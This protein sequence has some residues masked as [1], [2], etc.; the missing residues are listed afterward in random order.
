MDTIWLNYDP[1]VQYWSV[2][3][4]WPNSGNLLLESSA[5]F[6]IQFPFLKMLWFCA[7]LHL[8]WMKKIHFAYV[9]EEYLYIPTNTGHPH[10]DCLHRSAFNEKSMK[11]SIPWGQYK[12]LKND[13]FDPQQYCHG[14]SGL[15]CQLLRTHSAQSSW[16]QSYTF[17]DEI[18]IH[19]W[20]I[21]F[22]DAGQK[23]FQS[24]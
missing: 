22:M 11:L 18:Y 6:W 13:I 16:E 8:C 23:C 9:I 4:S 1:T 19:Y 20:H 7:F 14:R 15:S 12:L 17:L 3:G 10:T 5:A 24:F 2:V 21:S